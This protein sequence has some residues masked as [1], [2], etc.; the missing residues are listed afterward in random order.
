MSQPID[1]TDA[2][3]EAEVLRA[4]RTVLV[5][6]WADWCGP[7]KTL[8]PVLGEIAAEHAT[9]LKVAKVDIDL[10]HGVAS[11]LGVYSA[12]TMVIFKGG[13][14]VDRITGALPKRAL[15]GRLEDH[16]G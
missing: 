8:A 7:C 6:F 2:T 14:A 11:T 16:L 15:L 5:D 1:V 4:D 10:N 12:P 3:F 9:R 13:Q